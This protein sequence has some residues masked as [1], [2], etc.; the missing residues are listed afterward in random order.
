[1]AGFT[2]MK[3]KSHNIKNKILALRKGFNKKNKKNMDISVFGSEPP[4]HPPNMDKTK[5]KTCC[6]LGF[7]AHLEQKN[8]WSFFT[9]QPTTATHWSHQLPP[10]IT[11]TN[12]WCTPL[13]T[14]TT[15]IYHGEWCSGGC[16]W[17]V[18]SV[19]VGSGGCQRWWVGGVGWQWWVMAATVVLGCNSRCG[20]RVLLD[21]VPG[22]T[23]PHPPP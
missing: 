6:F 11:A 1:M 13:P 2:S 14:P 21:S 5:K 3:N 17:L 23:H 12:Y 8:L 10:P 7:L 22:L 4:T 19:V 15:A 16:L 9:L 20:H 18:A